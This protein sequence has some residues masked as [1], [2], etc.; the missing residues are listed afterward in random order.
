MPRVLRADVLNGDAP[1]PGPGLGQ[2]LRGAGGG[3]VGPRLRGGR[4]GPAPRGVGRGGPVPRGRLPGQLGLQA[5]VDIGPRGHPGGRLRRGI[6][7]TRGA[8]YGGNR[9][10]GDKSADDSDNAETNAGVNSVIAESLGNLTKLVTDLQERVERQSGDIKE[11]VKKDI[12]E[13]TSKINHKVTTQINNNLDKFDQSKSEE[14]FKFKASG[15][16]ISRIVEVRGKL[17]VALAEGDRDFDAFSETKTGKAIQEALDILD[18]Q[19][20]LIRLAENSKHGYKL[21]DKLKEDSTGYSYLNDPELV[22]RIKAA[23]K[24]L[25]KEYEANSKKSYGGRWQSGAR[26]RSRSRS[27]SPA[28]R[29]KKSA[30]PPRGRGFGFQCYWCGGQGHS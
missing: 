24:D 13:E 14:K 26:N 5:R 22:K 7:P 11:S 19:E 9:A 29:E 20:G 10:E 21:V 25:E 27:R 16:A 2:V 18:R 8:G 23:E 1:E 17:R 3:R 30:S 6:R 28:R 15:A 4:G 12:E